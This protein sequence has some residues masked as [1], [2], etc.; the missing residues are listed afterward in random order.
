MYFFTVSE[1]NPQHVSDTEASSDVNGAFI[2]ESFGFQIE[3][4]EFLIAGTLLY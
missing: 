2:D 1:I 4:G 3:P